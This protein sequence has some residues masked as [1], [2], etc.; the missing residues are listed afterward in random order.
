MRL[1]RLRLLP[2]MLLLALGCGESDPIVEPLPEPDGGSDALGVLAGTVREPDGNPLSEVVV[3]LEE[4]EDGRVASLQ[5]PFGDA[6]LAKGALRATVSDDE[7][8]YAFDFVL[9]G[10]YSL[11]ARSEDHLAARQ[12]L[13]MGKAAAETTIVDIDLTPTGN[14]AGVVTRENAVEHGGSLVFVQG[15]SYAAVS[16]STGA[17]QISDVPIGSWDLRAQYPGHRD[18][19]TQGTLSTA[20]EVANLAPLFLRRDSNIAP[21]AE[22]FPPVVVT[23]T[24]PVEF[25]GTGSD[26][27]GSIVLYEWDFEDDGT[28]DHADS[29]SAQTTHLYASAGSYRAKLRVTDDAGAIGLDVVEFELSANLAPTVTAQGPA[30]GVVSVG[31]TASFGGSASDPD[32]TVDLYEWDFDGDGTFDFSDPASA[33]AQHVYASTGSYTA[34]LRVTDDGGQTASDSTTV[35]VVEAGIFVASTGSDLAAGTPAQPKA[36]IG[37]GLAAASNQG[38]DRVFVAV[39]SYGDA[40]TLIDGIDLLGARSATTWEYL[41]GQYSTAFATA[42]PHLASNLSTPTLVQGMDF[43][44][45]NSASGNSIAL[46]VVSSADALTFDRCRFQSRSAG[47]GAPGDDGNPG[48]PGGDGQNGFP[49]SCD[50]SHGAGGSGGSGPC[51]GGDG[52]RGGLEGSN[53]GENGGFG[54]CG[55]PPGG[56]GGFGDDTGTFNCAAQGE[57]GGNGQNGP[58]GSIGSNGSPASNGGLANVSGWSPLTSGLGTPGGNGRGGSGGGGGGG[59]GGTFCNSG[60]G[61]GGGGGGAGG[62]GGGPGLGGQGGFASIAVYLYDS[63][64]TFD[65][66]IFFSG[67]GGDGGAGGNGALGASG[68]LGGTGASVCTSEVGRGGDGGDGGDGAAG[69]GGAGGPGGPS[70]CLAL[71]GGS[72]PTLVSPGYTPGSAGAGGS[73]GLRPGASAAPSGPSGISTDVQTF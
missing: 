22:A 10:R 15:T 13:V 68:G 37:A 18:D 67:A 47:D 42:S 64:P 5:D 9:E 1:A 73:G 7:G 39:G 6:A 65:T 69:G 4:I 52:G 48:A 12:E 34:V 23:S 66:C 46:R 36:T 28:F 50:G 55:G 51:P 29:S 41:E 35:S 71:A 38:L 44:S 60:G 2:L 27:D 8:R 32:G 30:G 20:G 16:D 24:V 26:P 49:G 45:G 19:S 59:Q 17:Y 25:D 62:G 11:Q 54:G 43:Q 40:V 14:F 63:S 70:I 31:E 21:T 3:T 61:N 57:P 56:S 58:S 72:S 33:V 53:R